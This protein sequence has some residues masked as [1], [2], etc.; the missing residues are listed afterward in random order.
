[1]VITGS[2]PVSG[3]DYE[4][5]GAASRQIKECLRRIGAG[6]RMVRR[7]MIATYEAEMNVVVHA[8]SG[9]VHYTIGP[10]SLDVTATDEG[11]GIPDIPLA[12]TEGFSTAPPEA[13]ALGFGAGMGLP[14][15]RRNA[16][17]FE[18]RSEPGRG[19][20]VRFSIE[21]TPEGAGARAR[22]SLGVVG[23]CRGCMRCVVACPTRA[24][25]VRDGTPAPL[26][27]LCIDCAACI[28]VCPDRALGL[29]GAGEGGDVR[30]ALR[31]AEVVVPDAFVSQF[32]GATFDDVSRALHEFGARR[33]LRLS[34]WERATRAASSEWASAHAHG[35]VLVPA[36]P[37]AVNLV[38][39]RF[40]S[41]VK[42]LA[43]FLSPVEAALHTLWGRRGAVVALCPAMRTAASL[44]GAAA[45]SAKALRAPVEEAMRRAP[46]P[47]EPARAGGADDAPD[48]SG[49]RYV[50]GTKAVVAALEQIERA[51]VVG[52]CVVELSLCNGGCR[53]SPL[54]A[55]R[56]LDARPPASRASPT[57]GTRAVPRQERYLP[58]GGLR[59]DR[60]MTSA[61]RKLARI[62]EVAGQLPGHDCAAC[63]APDCNA[64]AED[65]VL[66]RAAPSS[67]I[68]ARRGCGE[69][70]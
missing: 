33:V 43:P 54:V 23:A 64:L 2:I 50:S 62:G 49:V 34:G 17:G 28:E 32:A 42:N 39:C 57:Y 11:P 20:F 58:R 36:C 60:D 44:S 15:I 24:M 59:L 18:I 46:R 7:A 22:N 3:G 6:A 21:M 51:E 45:I 53:G 68:R 61:I 69:V 41:L 70:T 4:G 37:A 38:A 5:A 56:P 63:G 67:C 12:M 10:E 8:R 40:P 35:P 25:R 52:P 9:L 31:D 55:R 14:S 26:R 47:T 19:T 27:H 29:E 65:I 16:D 13:R 66:G 30:A 1:M 48:P